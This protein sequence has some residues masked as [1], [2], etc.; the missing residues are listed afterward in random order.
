[1]QTPPSSCGLPL[2]PVC[3]SHAAELPG[4]AR[5]VR[6]TGRSTGGLWAGSR[7]HG[8]SWETLESP[9]R[10][11]P[12]AGEGQQLGPQPPWFCTFLEETA[13][14]GADESLGEIPGLPLECGRG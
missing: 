11:G 8:S 13:F 1:M 14:L 12:C 4:A 6:K 7:E 3:P 2:Q 9:G 10:R 5:A